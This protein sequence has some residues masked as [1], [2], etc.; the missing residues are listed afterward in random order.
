M[1]D[2]IICFY[3]GERRATITNSLLRNDKYFFVKKHLDFLTKNVEM[4]KDINRVVFIINNSNELDSLNVSNI[5]SDSTISERIEVLNRGNN[6][7][8]Y[9]GWNDALTNN[10]DS[11]S[12]YAFLCEDDYI[13]A[14]GDFYKHFINYFDNDVAYVCQL[15]MHNHAAISNG[16]ISYEKCRE[17]KSIYGSV[18]NLT[19]V[20]GTYTAAEVDQVNF[21]NYFNKYRK[22]DITDKY[23]SHFYE[24]YKTTVYGNVN[25]IE[26]I[27]PI[28]G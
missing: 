4:L 21:L 16:F 13:P 24:F 25:G 1:F 12:E 28:L 26:L 3:F 5:I 27:K 10:L 15:F 8:S 20:V 19:H 11:E 23:F 18:F 2:Y 7:Y 6:N 14:I 22:L 17:A 9:G